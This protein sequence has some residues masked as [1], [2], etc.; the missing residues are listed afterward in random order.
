M[1]LENEIIKNM[2]KLELNRILQKWSLR[3]KEEKLEKEWHEL[4]K[5]S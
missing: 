3:F 2:N 1:I 4:R 5:I